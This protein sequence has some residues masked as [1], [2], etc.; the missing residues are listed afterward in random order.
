MAV[1]KKFYTNGNAAQAFVSGFISGFLFTI[2]IAIGMPPWIVGGISSVVAQIYEEINEGGFTAENWWVAVLRIVLV[3]IIGLIGGGVLGK[4]G[5]AEPANMVKSV[6]TVALKDFIK[7]FSTN[8]GSSIISGL[9]LGVVI[10]IATSAVKL[11]EGIIKWAYNWGDIYSKRIMNYT[12]Y[13]IKKD[14]KIKDEE[15]NALI[16]FERILNEMK[17]N[18]QQ[19]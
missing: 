9:L 11:I 17:S 16:S 5:I 4:W 8:L 3:G 15:L 19:S 6:S 2:F 12:W 7:S 14:Y 13:D 1:N 10:T 18:E